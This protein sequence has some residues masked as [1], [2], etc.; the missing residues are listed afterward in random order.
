MSNIEWIGSPPA[1]TGAS[2]RNAPPRHKPA[3]INFLIT[4]PLA[5]HGFRKTSNFHMDKRN[6]LHAGWLYLRQ[7]GHREIVEVLMLISLQLP[8]TA[9]FPPQKL[10]SCAHFIA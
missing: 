10:K 2:R 1:A 7:G 6:P 5:K 4:H 9:F 8:S 3:P